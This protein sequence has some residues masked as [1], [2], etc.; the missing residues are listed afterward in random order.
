VS[1]TPAL[2]TGPPWD[3]GWGA[4]VHAAPE[5]VRWQVLVTPRLVLSYASAAGGSSPPVGPRGDAEACT[6]PW[7]VVGPER[8]VGEG[9]GARLDGGLAL[10]P[11]PILLGRDGAPAVRRALARQPAEEILLAVDVAV[12]ESPPLADAAAGA[13]RSVVAPAHNGGARLVA[14]AV[15]GW[16]P[17]DD[18]APGGARSAFVDRILQIT[19]A[20]VR[21]A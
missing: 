17:P 14:L 1:F 11:Q 6:P 10:V 19:L 9:L 21:T 15:L 5:V 13:I 3:R 12:A 18:P 4:R 7:L 16:P 2:G 20:A 8:L